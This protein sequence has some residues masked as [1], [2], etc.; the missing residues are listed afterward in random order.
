MQKQQQKKKTLVTKTQSAHQET[1]LDVCHAIGP[2]LSDKHKTLELVPP[3]WH[4]RMKTLNLLM[5]LQHAVGQQR[6]PLGSDYLAKITKM[7]ANPH[8]VSI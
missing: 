5:W 4:L 2:I 7:S 8:Y 6:L 3:S 1:E